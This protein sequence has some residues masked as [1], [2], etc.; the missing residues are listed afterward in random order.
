MNTLCERQRKARRDLGACTAY[1]LTDGKGKQR[2]Q[3]AHRYSEILIP[4]LKSAYLINPI[5]G[6]MLMSFFWI[7]PS[8]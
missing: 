3:I 6:Y 8:T 4:M 1:L 7:S 5:S 2:L